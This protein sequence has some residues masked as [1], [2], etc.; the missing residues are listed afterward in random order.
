MIVK[1]LEFPAAVVAHSG[2]RPWLGALVR[3]SGPLTAEGI[4]SFGRF[5]HPGG[6]TYVYILSTAA[7]LRDGNNEAVVWIYV[8]DG[9]AKAVAPTRRDSRIPG[10]SLPAEAVV[11]DDLEMQVPFTLLGLDR[12]NATGP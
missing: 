7:W 1:D 6:S 11:T 5:D 4:A 10:F 9:S 2:S 12:W 3:T 8:V